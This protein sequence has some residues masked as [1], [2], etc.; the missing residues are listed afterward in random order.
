VVAYAAALAVATLAVA[1]PADRQP[2]NTVVLDFSSLADSFPGGHD[3]APLFVLSPAEG[4][5]RPYTLVS[6]GRAHLCPSGSPPRRCPA[7]KE[8][9][10]PIA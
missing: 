7:S 2:R 10:L 9:R 6:C 5:W 1:V 8:N 4:G 3:R